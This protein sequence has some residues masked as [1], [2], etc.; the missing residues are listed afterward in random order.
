MAVVALP[1]AL[2]S[3]RG[4]PVVLAPHA[5]A[6]PALASHVRPALVLPERETRD[7]LDAAG[8]HDVARGGCFSAGPA[9]VQVWS[10]AFDG[11]GGSPGG[12]LHLGSVDWSYDTP[13]R[14]YVTIYR[15]MVTEAGVE[16]GETTTS[17]LGYVLGL[18]GIPLE[19]ERVQMPLAPRATRF[20]VGCC[21]ALDR[22]GLH[23]PQAPYPFWLAPS[24]VR[25]M[26]PSTLRTK[27]HSAR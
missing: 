27:R 5:V 10:H 25:D 14:H 19:G 18:T 9:G 26:V 23:T 13:V 2:G 4:T 22:Y 12:A 1:G 3:V 21:P 20:A 6:V 15:A 8:R 7:L 11:P 16:R 24:R 17:V